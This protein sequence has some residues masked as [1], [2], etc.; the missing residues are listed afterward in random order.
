MEKL[1]VLT[2]D[3]VMNSQN[4]IEFLL[5]GHVQ[6]GRITLLVG[7]SDSGKSYFC[8]D[9]ARAVCNGDE[10]FLGWNIT[11][12]H[13]AAL[14]VS[15]EDFCEDH[16]ER[17]KYVKRDKVR[18]MSG[19]KFIYNPENLPHVLKEYLKTNP[20]DLVV[21]DS[22]GDF[23]RGNL[24]DS[25]SVR[26]FFSDFKKI[27]YEHRC[28]ILFIHHIPKN[29]AANTSPSKHD[30]LGSEALTS[31]CRAVLNFKK[32]APW[33]HMV[34]VTKGNQLGDDKKDKGLIIT[35]D[36]ENLFQATS[37]IID[38][39][40]GDSRNSVGVKNDPKTVERVL[41]LDSKGLTT[42][43]ITEKMR[44]EGFKIGKTTVADI[45]KRGNS[46]KSDPDDQILNAA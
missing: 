18:N 19:F 4:E 46:K 12:K 13:N 24:N 2:F 39:S 21:I 25:I 10:E 20:T 29:K 44:E 9:F 40:T 17:L 27:A 3:E 31:A 6:T 42:R 16:K 32:T 26:Q 36:K 37:E 41:E 33:K 38:F 30:A 34:T 8:L 1:Q 28:A 7:E 14:F 35:F 23:F 11:A 45:I 5:E 43:A 22:L 15:S